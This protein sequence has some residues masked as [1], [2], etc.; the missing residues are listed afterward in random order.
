[1]AIAARVADASGPS[2]AAVAAMKTVANEVVPAPTPSI[3]TGSASAA[4]AAAS[5]A[6]QASP[7]RQFPSTRLA[8]D[9]A[10]AATPGTTVTATAA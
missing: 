2:S 9:H 7:G 5:A 8:S 3:G 1:M 4:V 10:A 6:S